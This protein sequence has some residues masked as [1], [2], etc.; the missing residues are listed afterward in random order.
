MREK[1]IKKMVPKFFQ[2]CRYLIIQD[3]LLGV[4]KCLVMRNQAYHR[5]QKNSNTNI[6]RWIRSG[7]SHKLH[8]LNGFRGRGQRN[9]IARNQRNVS[10]MMCESIP[11]A[12]PLP[13][14]LKTGRFFHSARIANRRNIAKY[15]CYCC[16]YWRRRKFRK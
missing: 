4:R 12:S 15:R 13:I 9:C 11:R 10:K 2:I 14:D 6:L 3:C 7:I 16:C 8:R 5:K 1:N